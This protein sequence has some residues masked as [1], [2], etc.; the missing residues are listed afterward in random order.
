[1]KI[2]TQRFI[3]RYVG[4]LIC[5]FFSSYYRIVKKEP[6]T[7]ETKK[8]LIILLSEMGALVLA[9]PMFQRLKERYPRAE[10]HVMLFEKNREVVELLELVPPENII[11][12]KDTSML[13]FILDTLKGL[14][15]MRKLKFD[16]VIDCELF[17]RISSILAF[18]SG[19]VVRVGFHAHTQEGLYRGNF[20]NRPVLYN[21]YHHISR[22]FLTLV[23][24]ID[25]SSHPRAKYR[26]PAQQLKIPAIKVTSQEI[27]KARKRL[28]AKA[29]GLEGRKLVLIYPGGG[30]LPIRAWPV[31]NYCTL[32]EELLHRGYAVCVIG[33]AQDQQIATVILSHTRSRNCVDLTGYT[34]TIRDLILI[35]HFASLLITNDGGPGH[36]AALTPIPS[37]IFYGP[38]TPILYGPL[39]LKAS[40]IFLG[41][42]CS[43]CVTAYNHRNS[44]CDGDNLCLKK[45]E[46]D[47]VLSK[48]LEIL[49]SQ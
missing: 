20:I 18:L 37:I 13:T 26:V 25:S 23:E 3:D 46:P 30:L 2:E 41:L 42:S 43:P 14:S 36:F 19:A 29:P 5:R 40:N 45:I 35:F 34:Q 28:F 33:L 39:D 32:A 47:Y 8:I 12:I 4:S 1:M 11:T 16:T 9:H 15:R 17:S 22:Q 31:E 27:E 44:P 7:P 6:A 24:T 38:E 48:A 10:L 21:P 49:E